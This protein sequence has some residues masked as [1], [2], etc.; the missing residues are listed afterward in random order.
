MARWFASQEFNHAHLYENPHER[1]VWTGKTCQG[2]GEGSIALA[3][4]AVLAIVP[5]VRL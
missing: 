4:V 1:G 5:K 2:A 3:R